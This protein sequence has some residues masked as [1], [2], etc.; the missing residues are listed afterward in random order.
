MTGLMWWRLG[1]VPC[2]YAEQQASGA[3]LAAPKRE[4]AHFPA[5]TERP[6][7][8]LDSNSPA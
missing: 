8:D 4:F 7:L 2:E 3:L 5:E 6:V 1:R